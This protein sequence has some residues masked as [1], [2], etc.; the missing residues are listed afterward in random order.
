MSLTIAEILETISDEKA[1]ALFETIALAQANGDILIT[2]MQ[3]TRKQYY[4]RMSRLTKS[5]LVKRRNG[6]YALT[7]FGKVIYDIQ[8]TIKKVVNNY[9]WKLKAVDS[10]EVGL[11]KEEHNKALDALIDNGKMKEVILAKIC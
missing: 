11:S 9:Y 1:L 3:L 7:S 10:F 2:K 8:L 4:S 5:G 6:R